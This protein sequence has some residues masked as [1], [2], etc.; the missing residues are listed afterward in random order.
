MSGETNV[1][2]SQVLHINGMI[3]KKTF[4]RGCLEMH[5]TIQLSDRVKGLNLVHEFRH[6]L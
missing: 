1:N 5:G 2:T 4:N 6:R 3:K